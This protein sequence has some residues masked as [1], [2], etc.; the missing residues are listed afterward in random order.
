VSLRVTVDNKTDLWLT[1]ATGIPEGTVKRRSVALFA[2]EAVGVL[3]R[4]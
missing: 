2:V 1:V 4:G 3:N